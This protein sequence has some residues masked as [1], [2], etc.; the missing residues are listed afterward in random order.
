MKDMKLYLISVGDSR[1]FRL[2]A[3]DGHEIQVKLENELNDYLKKRFPEGNYAYFTSPRL[4]EIPVEE[5]V[6]YDAYPEFN[7]EAVSE[8]EHVLSTEI[9]AMEADRQL[10]NNAPTADAPLD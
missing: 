8:I 7:A 9:E 1:E 6:K 4:V 10:N 5:E 3:E 2:R